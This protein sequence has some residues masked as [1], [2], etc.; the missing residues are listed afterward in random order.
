MKKVIADLDKLKFIDGKGIPGITLKWTNFIASI[1]LMYLKKIPFRKLEGKET[2][3]K[4]IISLTT[5]PKRNLASVYA[6]KSLL[7]QTLQPYKIIVWLANSQY[8]SLPEE[9]KKLQELG[10]EFRFVPDIKSHKKYYFA[11]QEYPN[12][13]IVTVDDDLIFPEDLIEQLYLKH[14]DFPDAIVCFRGRTI[15]LN[16][17]G[18]I[19]PYEKWLINTSHGIKSPS[20]KIMPSTGSGTL[21]PPNSYNNE[22]FDIEAIKKNALYADD[23]WVKFI[24]LK[25]GTKVIKTHD[26]CRY[27][28]PIIIRNDVKLSDY[29]VT[30]KGNDLVIGNLLKKYPGIER[31][32]K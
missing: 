19:E 5:F 22:L 27:L 16:Q 23:L 4:I 24:T 12:D 18:C 2:K 8:S 3:E 21:Y 29:N 9:F 11:L 28:S 10:V 1:Q 20:F 31:K 32:L 6:I 25:K 13:L 14:L 17:K 7:N 26:N 15:V 30:S